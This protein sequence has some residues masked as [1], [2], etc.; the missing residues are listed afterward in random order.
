MADTVLA[1]PTKKFF[2]EML[3]RDIDLED[4]ILDLLDNCIDGIL[5][6]TNGKSKS[7][8]PYQGY[9]AKITATPTKFT[10]EDNCGGI[11]IAIA[12][13]SA[14]MLG[15]PDNRDS[16]IE[17]VGM[18]GIGMK[19]AIFKMGRQCV[20]TSQPTKS[21]TYCV[22]ISPGWFNRDND[23]ELPIK[24]TTNRLKENGTRVEI[25]KLL[26]VMKI[27]FNEEESNFIGDLKD[28]ISELFALIIGK[29]FEVTVNDDPIE[30]VNLDILAPSKVGRA[31]KR[32]APYVFQGKV[33][34]VSV[35]AVVG[36]HRGLASESELEAESRASRKD[37]GWTMVCNDRIVL[38]ANKTR[39]TG[40]G[41]GGVP[42]YHNQFIAIRGM[43]VFRSKDSFLLPINT[44]K[45]GLDASSEVYLYVL[46]VMREGMKKFTDYTYKW[47]TRTDETVTEFKDLKK[48]T[49]KEIV[50]SVPEA[51]WKK[52]RKGGSDVSAK[53]FMPDLPA[54]SSQ[55]VNKRIQFSRKT[56][57]VSIVAEYLFE[58]ADVSASEVG[59]QCFDEILKEAK[60]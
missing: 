8:K 5:R 19:R 23:W 15:R 22:T 55:S 42:A 2:V 18:Y 28:R 41:T 14:F 24:K 34:G 12:E 39:L 49:V 35:S 44:T 10:I 30:P 3:T 21:T 51:N 40:W 6:Q 16:N 29:G 32:I 37:A 57:D 59:A 31:K 20:V 36:F 56:K 4:A 43:V 9:W 25:T 48:R 45:R 53:K 52:V 60:S 11:P 47:K 17:T 26:D 54:P 27:K 33:K 7:K 46:D 1:G 13:K 38:Y 58:D 50:S